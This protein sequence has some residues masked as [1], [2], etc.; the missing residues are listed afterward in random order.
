M[1]SRGWESRHNMLNMKKRIKMTFSTKPL[2]NVT[3]LVKELEEKGFV[4]DDTIVYDDKDESVI[5]ALFD[6]YYVPIF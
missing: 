1:N 4:V 2:T 5:T 3:K 6:K